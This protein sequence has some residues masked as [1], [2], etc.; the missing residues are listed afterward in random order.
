MLTN[1]LGAV[2]IDSQLIDLAFG[3]HF[4]T[5]ALFCY[6]VAHFTELPLILLYI[7]NKLVIDSIW[8]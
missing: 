4:C 8:S 3:F 5:V 1:M 2:C 7:H 6:A